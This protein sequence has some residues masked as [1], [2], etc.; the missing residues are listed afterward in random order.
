ME[1]KKNEIVL[2]T[3]PSKA[4]RTT[5][6]TLLISG[7]HKVGKTDALSKLEGCAIIE[8]EPGGTDYVDAIKLIPP[9][10]IG[11]VSKRNW[12]KE[13]AK[14]IKESG[15]PYKYVAIDTFSQLDMDAEWWGTW[16]YMNSIIGKNF[17]RDNNGQMIRPDSPNYQSVLTLPNGAG[18]YYTRTAILD[19]FDILDNNT[20]HAMMFAESLT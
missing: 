6:N 15:R 12:L 8:T 20:K 11:P 9:K 7:K 3:A 17:N 13:V 5:P 16:D 2:P 14:K 4:S 18:Y 1:E 19:M 10:D